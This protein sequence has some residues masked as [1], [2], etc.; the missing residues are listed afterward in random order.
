[1]HLTCKF[2]ARNRWPSAVTQGNAAARRCKMNHRTELLYTALKRVIEHDK[3]AISLMCRATNDVISLQK[4]VLDA[5]ALEVEAQ[6]NS[7]LRKP[8]QSSKN[9]TSE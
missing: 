7:R 5:R 2:L 1:M 9:E 3:V 4:S 6:N 8:C